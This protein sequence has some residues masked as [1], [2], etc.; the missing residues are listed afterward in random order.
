ML[1]YR[2]VRS[3]SH[4]PGDWSGFYNTCCCDV[5][6]VRRRAH[7]YMMSSLYMKETQDWFFRNLNELSFE[8]SEG[9]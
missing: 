9:S 8:S 1:K 4:V 5:T 7:C 2:W 3:F 6:V